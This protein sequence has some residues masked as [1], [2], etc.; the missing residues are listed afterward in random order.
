M[1]RKSCNRIGTKKATLREN[2]YNVGMD[3]QLIL[4]EGICYL[5]LA[6]KCVQKK[7]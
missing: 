7:I 3:A 2:R 6:I 4:P 5:A 1:K